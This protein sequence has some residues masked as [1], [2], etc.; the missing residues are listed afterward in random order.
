MDF[1][2]F[3]DS[4]TAEQPPEGLNSALLGLWWQAKGDWARAHQ[5]AQ[6]DTGEDAAW[7]HAYLHRVEGDESNAGYWYRRAGRPHCSDP[8]RQEWRDI[9]GALTDGP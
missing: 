6:S 3:D 5:A 1:K 9:A 2:S 8:L 4:L 7:V